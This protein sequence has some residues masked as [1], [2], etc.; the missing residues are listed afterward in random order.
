MDDW[1]QAPAMYSLERKLY[2]R[3]IAD[4]GLGSDMGDET[5]TSEASRVLRESVV[6][7]FLQ[8]SMNTCS[9]PI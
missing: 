2:E 6:T 8:I 7:R 4:S 5:S 1:V 9:K 3:P